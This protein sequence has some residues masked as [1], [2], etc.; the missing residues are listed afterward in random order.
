MEFN[1]G[2]PSNCRFC[3]IIVTPVAKKNI[4]L[5]KDFRELYKV[6]FYLLCLIALEKL[7]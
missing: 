7:S 4:V 3:W 2:L 1:S 5:L 6:Y